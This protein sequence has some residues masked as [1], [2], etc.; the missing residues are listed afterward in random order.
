MRPLRLPAR[1]ARACRSNTGARRPPGIWPALKVAPR[2][3]GDG[4]RLLVLLALGALIV[5]G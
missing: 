1:P 2:R 5:D 3:P 4:V